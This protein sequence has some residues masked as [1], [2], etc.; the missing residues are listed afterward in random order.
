MIA[1]YTFPGMKRRSSILK[2]VLPRASNEDKM[3]N[4]INIVCETTGT[5]VVNVLS[6][7][8]RREHVFA[9]HLAMYMIREKYPVI[10]L[11]SIGNHLGGRD[12]TTT[13][14]AIESV[15]NYLA[16]EER[17]RAVVD[18]IRNKLNYC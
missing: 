17:T 14:H 3:T 13:I 1:Y 12:H 9:R 10:S 2:S 16:T 5:D 4:I 6:K 11:K 7:S 18:E 8:R 15:K